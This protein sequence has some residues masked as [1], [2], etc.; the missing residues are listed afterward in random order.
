METTKTIE[1]NNKGV[2]H[3]LNRD[4]D[5]AKECYE[6]ALQMD[7]EDATALNNLGLLFHHL[8][9]FDN[10]ISSFKKAISK[11]CNPSYLVNLGNTFAAIKR[12]KESENQYWDALKIS[13]EHINAWVC[14]AKLAVYQKSFDDA[15]SYWLEAFNLDRKE[16][17]ILEIAKLYILN[18][19]YNQALEYLTVVC[20]SSVNSEIFF[21]IGR[22]EFHLRN[23]GLAEKTFKRAISGQ[24]DRVDFR[25]YLALNYIA[26]GKI[27]KGLQQYD[28]ILKAEPDNYHILTEKGVV[29]CGIFQ[30]D[31]ALTC[32][33]KV[34]D[35]KPQCPKAIEYKTLISSMLQQPKEKNT[36]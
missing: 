29:L 4:F 23:H 20:N 1:L 22:C 16:E 12:F 9:E 11:K 10:A 13:R 34:L 33:N 21:Q 19:N 35:L 36:I 26:M 18:K 3:F 2:Q 25:Q 15:V 17:Y 28:L 27:H 6:N 32:F 24:P 14:L 31:Q 7:P 30:L 8:K 5:K